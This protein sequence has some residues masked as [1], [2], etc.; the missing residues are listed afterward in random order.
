MVG[1]RRRRKVSDKGMVVGVVRG[2]AVL[3]DWVKKE[4]AAMNVIDGEDGGGSM[5]LGPARKRKKAFDKTL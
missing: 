2:R 4:G 1:L 5:S 3:A